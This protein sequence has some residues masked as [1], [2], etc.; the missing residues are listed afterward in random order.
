MKCPECQ[1]ENP[2]SAMFCDECGARLESPCPNCGEPNRHGAKFCRNCG[3]VISPS[4]TKT[5][6][7][8]LGV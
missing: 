5:P 2:V 4:G 3:Q 7:M 1:S 8:A 6:S